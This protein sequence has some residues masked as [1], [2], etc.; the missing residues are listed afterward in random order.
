MQKGEFSST[1]SILSNISTSLPLLSNIDA[2]YSNNLAKKLLSKSDLFISSNSFSDLINMLNSLVASLKESFNNQFKLINEL[3]RNKLDPDSLLQL[4]KLGTSVNK[5]QSSI[6]R[7]DD[8]LQ[9][10]LQASVEP[11]E[12]KKRDLIQDALSNINQSMLEFPEINKQF[13]YSLEQPTSEITYQSILSELPDEKKVEF[14]QLKEYMDLGSV[15][16]KK[17]V[18]S[19]SLANEEYSDQKS[20]LTIVKL[21]VMSANQLNNFTVT[22][23]IPKSQGV[24]ISDIQSTTPFTV[25]NEDPIIQFNLGTV[26]IGETKTITYVISK[27]LTSYSSQSFAVGQLQLIGIPS[28]PTPEEFVFSEQTFTIR[29]LAA[30]FISLF[31][32]I[33]FLSTKQTKHREFTLFKRK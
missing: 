3:Q 11:D 29:L 7:L 13:S 31:I 15:P 12:T 17:D 6:L 32:I 28:L 25:L 1:S 10:L 19:Y 24:E 23:Y 18:Y 2:S 33:E 4:N 30:V 16:V 5:M 8:V 9:T 14:E 26:A 21:T 27:K 20:D 22:E